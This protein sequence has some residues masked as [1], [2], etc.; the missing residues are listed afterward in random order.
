M[1]R[2][3]DSTAAAC[4]S[5]QGR[6][7]GAFRSVLGRVLLAASAS[8]L[9]GCP[10]GPPPYP[11][12]KPAAPPA[13]PAPP[14]HL[15]MRQVAP[16]VLDD[17]PVYAAAGAE[18]G[19]PRRVIA[20]P[21]GPGR[22]AV[23]GH[24]ATCH[25]LTYVL[26]QPP[27]E[28][29]GWT[30]VVTKMQRVHG[31]VL[32]AGVQDEVVAYLR[33]HFGPATVAATWSA[34]DPAPAP[35][36]LGPGARVFAASCS[37]CHQQDGRGLAGAFPPLAGRAGRLAA[38]DRGYPLRVVLFGLQGPLKIGAATYDNAMPGWPQ[39]PD[40]ELA[41]VLNHVTSLGGGTAAGY[42]ADEVAAA[43][44]KALTPQEV[45]ASRPAGE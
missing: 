43:R 19:W 4:S 24:C 20:L 42:T 12:S 18:A 6:R 44:G 17:G 7:R 29:G 22:E 23:E 35:P 25:G 30:A 33:D 15:P 37:P 11:P 32:P 45:H 3:R 2:P 8:G 41:A 21:D 38:A 1:A 26:A 34:L 13:P 10:P 40:D 28:A 5:G 9:A 31:A 27:L 14:V 39:L 16:P 36:A